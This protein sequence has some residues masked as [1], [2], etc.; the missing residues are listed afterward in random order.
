MI[1]L[2]MYQEF[3]SYSPHF[4]IRRKRYLFYF[5]FILF[6]SPNA[7]LNAQ[8][9]PFVVVLDAGHGGHDSGNRGNGY[10]EKKIAL[11]IALK[12]GKQLENNKDFKVIYTRKSDV[13]VDLIERANIANRSDA[14]LFISIHCD[15]FSSS[16]AFGAGTF[17]LGLHDNERNFKVA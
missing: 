13:F 14:D 15:A 17:V 5:L 8:E 2:R 4:N 1:F 11:T 6:I 16:R 7:L 9:K 12:I 10:F 3:L